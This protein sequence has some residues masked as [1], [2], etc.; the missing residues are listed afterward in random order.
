MYL[1]YGGWQATNEEPL[2][3]KKDDNDGAELM[4]QLDTTIF[5]IRLF[6]GHRKK[7]RKT[8][9]VPLK[10]FQDLINL[11]VNAFPALKKE[12]FHLEWEKT[13]VEDADDWEAVF[14]DWRETD[15]GM[16]IGGRRYMDLHII[17]DAQTLALPQPVPIQTQQ[18]QPSQP[19]HNTKR[20]NPYQQKQS[21]LATNNLSTS[22][23]ATANVNRQQN[24]G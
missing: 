18:L 5:Y 20:F 22:S 7:I 6:Y 11:A 17:S 24:N 15:S 14:S 4:K 10:T 19:N 2:T 21:T 8:S 9:F 3:L 12:K 1:S 13:W 23:W 16:N